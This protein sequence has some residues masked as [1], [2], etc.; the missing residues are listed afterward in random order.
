MQRV[1]VFFVA[2]SGGGALGRQKVLHVKVSTGKGNGG[3]AFVFVFVLRF[4]FMFGQKAHIKRMFVYQC[5]WG[6]REKV[7]YNSFF[8]HDLNVQN[9]KLYR[10]TDG[11]IF[12]KNL[13]I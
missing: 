12:E 2:S 7:A 1:G 11:L 5:G 13:E 6:C 9:S 4:I 8:K 10:Q 3:D